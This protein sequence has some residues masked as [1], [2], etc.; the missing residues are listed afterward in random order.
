MSRCKAMK[1]MRRAQETITC[2]PELLRSI[3]HV[4]DEGRVVP[5]RKI[6]LQHMTPGIW[7]NTRALMRMLRVLMRILRM[8][9]T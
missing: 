3:V 1:Q 2:D 8:W 4:L 5:G 9:L 7:P 6:M